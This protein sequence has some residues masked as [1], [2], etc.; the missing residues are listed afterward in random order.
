MQL[1]DM[2]RRQLEAM[3]G[4]QSGSDVSSSEGESGSDVSDSGDS[5]WDSTDDDE[6]DEDGVTLLRDKQLSRSLK[7]YDTSVRELKEQMRIDRRSARKVKRRI[8]MRRKKGKAPTSAERIKLER[9]IDLLKNSIDLSIAMQRA[10]MEAANA[11]LNLM[12]NRNQF[13]LLPP[14]HT[15]RGGSQDR[16]FGR[17]GFIFVDLLLIAGRYSCELMPT[18][19]TQ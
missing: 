16:F 10:V 4:E 5:V 15:T 19:D 2:R 8:K 14:T 12:R 3:K 1:E 13:F 6:L 18:F 9:R 17:C 7:Y 11:E